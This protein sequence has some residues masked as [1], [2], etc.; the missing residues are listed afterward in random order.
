MAAI[1]RYLQMS[2]LES[3]YIISIQ[4]VKFVP[5]CFDNKSPLIHGNDLV[6]KITLEWAHNSSSWQYI[7]YLIVA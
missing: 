5:D 1:D 7:H 2:F 3:K 4:I 6:P